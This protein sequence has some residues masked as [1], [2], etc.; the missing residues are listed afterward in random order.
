[1]KL[2]V[3]SDGT[4]AGTKVLDRE[5]GEELENVAGLHILIRSGKRS[6]VTMEILDPELMIEA[7]KSPDFAEVIV[8]SKKKRWIRADVMARHVRECGDDSPFVKDLLKTLEDSAPA[9]GPKGD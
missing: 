9:S 4:I 5:T 1:M 2:K 3:I 8:D 6:I 7:E